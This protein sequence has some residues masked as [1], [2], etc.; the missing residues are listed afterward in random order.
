MGYNDWYGQ[1]MQ[2]ETAQSFVNSGKGVG[3]YEQ[4]YRQNGAESRTKVDGSTQS[5]EGT[6][7]KPVKTD[8]ASS[9]GEHTYVPWEDELLSAAQ[10]KGALQTKLAQEQMELDKLNQ[11]R[12]ALLETYTTDPT[13]DNAL[14]YELAD[15]QYGIANENYNK[16]FDRYDKTYEQEVLYN[17]AFRWNKENEGAESVL[18]HA[19]SEKDIQLAQRLMSQLQ[20]QIATRKKA[21][22][23][24]PSERN[25]LLLNTA[26][27]RYAEQLGKYGEIVDT[28]N[29][30]N[31]PEEIRAQNKYLQNMIET[32]DAK[33]EAHTKT[34]EGLIEGFLE[35]QQQADVFRATRDIYQTE[36]DATG[37][38]YY[39]SA[40]ERERARM[41]EDQAAQDAY[42][43]AIDTEQDIRYINDWITA[44]LDA[45]PDMVTGYGNRNIEEYLAEA[46]A[47]IKEKYGIDVKKLLP[48]H[49]DENVLNARNVLG[50]IVANLSE[51]LPQFT[52]V[53]AQ[54]GYN[55]EYM[56]GYDAYIEAKKQYEE[57]EK[58]HREN[59]D[60]SGWMAFGAWLGSTAVKPFSGIE[61]LQDVVGAIGHSDLEDLENYIP[62][63]TYDNDVTNYVNVS[64]DA[65]GNSYF[66][67]SGFGRFAYNVGTSAVDSAVTKAIAAIPVVGKGLALASTAGAAA[68]D[69]M[70]DIAA[71]GGTNDQMIVGG[72]AAGIVEVVAEDI[73]IEKLFGDENLKKTFT[74]TLVEQ[75]LTEFGEEAVTEALMI[76]IDSVN[77]SGKSEFDTAVNKYMKDGY[78]R[79]DAQSKAFAD[80]ILRVFEAGTAG[81]FGGVLSAGTVGA[82]ARR[83]AMS[84]IG[85]DYIAHGGDVN[86]LIAAG[87]NA[88]PNSNA[89]KIAQR[90][91]QRIADG[92]NVGERQIGAGLIALD[93]Q[94][95]NVDNNAPVVDDVDATPET[96]SEIP[97]AGNEKTAS[98]ET[99]QG[100]I[101]PFSETEANN[102]SSHKGIVSG[103]GIT[104]RQFID[105]I[106]NIGNTVRYYFGKVSS[107]LGARISSATGHDVS[108][109]NIAIRSDE[110]LHTFSHHGDAKKEALRGHLPVTADVLER[111]PEVFNAPDDVVPLSE[112]D[113]AGR[114]AFEIRKY[115]DGQMVV[116]VGIS[117][118][119]HSIEIDTVYVIDKKRHPTTV[120]AAQDAPLDHTSETSS[121]E[122]TEGAKSRLLDAEASQL[123]PI[124]SNAHSAP[125]ASEYTDTTNHTVAQNNSTVNEGNVSEDGIR[126]AGNAAEID[127]AEQ[128]RRDYAVGRIT[129]E[130]FDQ[131][132]DALMEEESASEMGMV[133]GIQWAGNEQITETTA[134]DQDNN[135]ETEE[136]TYEE[137][138]G[139]STARDGARIGEY[140][141]GET[142]QDRGRRAEEEAQ[143]RSAER[144]QIQ[145][146]VK[147]L[148]VPLTS[149]HECGLSI[150]SKIRS[151][152]IIPQEAWTDSIQRAADIAAE[153]GLEFVPLTGILCVEI[154]GKT[155]RAEAVIENG[156]IYVQAD[157]IQ[158]DVVEVTNHEV[159]HAKI[160]GDP[161][162]QIRLVNH[163]KQTYN[164]E[165]ISNLIDRYMDIYNEFVD[166]M[167]PE[168]MEAYVWKEM[169]ADAY[170]DLERLSGTKGPTQWGEYV[171]G[172]MAQAETKNTAQEDGVTRMSIE[173]LPDGKKYVRAD[174]QVLYGNDPDAWSEQLEDY[175]NGK[176]RRGQDVQLLTD[177]GDVLTLTAN[178]AGKVSSRY[179]N[180]GTTMSD[181]AFERKANAGAH[182]DELAQ[183]SERGK[184]IVPD[185]DGK[186]GDAARDGWNYRTAFFEDFDGRRYRC[187]ISVEIGKD[188][189]A[190]YNIGKMQER[191]LPQFS[192]PSVR[193]GAQGGETSSDIS[194]S[195]DGENSNRNFSF[196]GEGAMTA[197]EAA[198]Q[199][200]KDMLADGEDMETIRQETGWYQGR[201]GKWRFEIDDSGMTYH[202][203]GDAQFRKDHPEYARY[204]DLQMRFIEGTITAEEETELR[205]LHEIW[206]REYARLSERVDEGSATLGSILDHEELYAAYPQLR[207]MVVRFDD[208][209][210]TKGVINHRRGVITLDNS[211]RNAPEGTLLHEIQHAIQE[212]EGFAKGSSPE[213]WD[214]QGYEDA[215]DRYRNTAGEIEARDVANRRSLTAEERRQRMPELG[216]EQTVFAENSY[217][218]MSESEQIGIREQL[219]ENQDKLNSMDVVG[220]VNTQEYA[221]LDTGK[222][223]EK[224]MTEMK[225]TG[226]K[227][228]R[229]G[230]GEIRFEEREINNSL[231]YK[232]KS[233]SAEDARRTGFLVL[234]NVLKRGIEIGGHDDH[235]GRN[236][237]TVTIAAPIEI[238]GERGNMAVVVKRTKGN[239]YKV[240][241]ILTPKGETFM[242]PEMANAEMNT[243]GAF[244]NGS[245]SLGGSAPA[246]NSASGSIISKDV[247]GVNTR[248]SAAASTEE[249]TDS[250]TLPAK[251]QSYLRQTQWNLTNRIGDLMDV[252]FMTRRGGL[253]DAVNRLANE[254]LQRGD[255]SQQTVDELFDVASGGRYDTD[256]DA[257][258]RF[259]N[260]VY[261][262]LEELRQI[263]RYVEDRA[264]ETATAEP[265]TQEDVKQLYTE[266]KTARRTAEKAV[267]KNL[268]TAEDE[269]QIGRLL[270]GEITVDGLDAGQYN[271]KG[272]KAVYEARAEHERIA[273][274]IRQWN[275]SRK[276][277]L[278]EDAD[279]FLQTANDWKDKSA[280]LLYSRETMERNIRDIVKD[281]E[282]AEQIIAEYFE[283]V[284]RG[285]AEANK[286][287]N[288]YRSEVKELNLSRK[289]EK[290]NV[291]S[292]AHAVQLLGEA[293]DNIQMLEQSKGRMKS[294][295]GKTL[296]E[297]RGVVQALWENN[298]H[299]NEAKIRSAVEAF[300][301][302]YDE[303]FVQMNEVRIR[304]GYEPINYRNGYFPHFQPGD[305]GIMAL[306]GKAL[307]IDTQV[308]ALPTTING[309]THTFRPGITWFGNAQE[310]LGFNTAYD[311]V[312]GFDRYIEGVADVIFHTDN[313]QRLR[314]LASQIRYRTGDEGIR[315]QVDAVRADT[316]L[317]EQDK[318]N[319]IEKIYE[320]GKYSL[321]NFV[322]EL[323]E[324]TNLLANK[325]SR[326]D[327]DIESD[328]GRKIYT[329]VKNLESRVA[330]NMVAVNPASWLTNFIPLTQGNAALEHGMLLR[331]MWNTLRAY[332]KTDDG[333]VDMSSFL[334]NRRG[335]DPIVKSWQDRASGKLS[336]P[337]EYIDQ[338][339]ADSLVRARY[340]QNL[341]HG[342]SEDASMREAD[343]WVAGVMADRSKGSM[344]TLFGRKNPMTKLFTQFQLEVNNQ[345]SYVMK[346]VPRDM[347]SKGAMALVAALIKFCLG[348][349][350]FDELYEY[351]IGR[352]PALDPLGIINDT[353]G[354]FTGY[355]LP[356]LVEMG[357]GAIKG[358]RPDF[359]TEKKGAYGAVSG[360]L[361][362]VAEEM[363]FVGGLLGGGRIPI[364]SALPDG[365]K[366][367]NAAL[368]SDWDSEKRWK[369]AV[370]ELGSSAAYLIPPFGGG[371]IKKIVETVQAVHNHGSYNASGNLQYPVFSDSPL[372]W[373]GSVTK[374]VLFGKS[375]L[376]PAVEW[377]ES[378]FDGLSEKYTAVYQIMLELGED[379]RTAWAVT[380][381]LAD[382]E[383]TGEESVAVVRRDILREADISA[384]AKLAIYYDICANDKEKTLIE[385]M[386][387]EDPQ[388]VYELLD[389]MRGAEKTEDNSEAEV[390]R[391]MLIE[392]DLPAEAKLEVYT[393]NYASDKERAMI[394]SLTEDDPE[395]IYEVVDGIKEAGNNTDKMIVLFT[396]DLRDN[397]KQAV[398]EYISESD[399]E[400][401]GA[402]SNYVDFDVYGRFLQSFVREYGYGA[403]SQDEVEYILDHTPGLS[404]QE[405]AAIWQI[406]NKGW[407]PKNNP[408][409]VEVGQRIYDQMN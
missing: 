325:K 208:L 251:A 245:Q 346:D 114:T 72:L 113:Y 360:L 289:V 157:S 134:E 216:N 326:H 124:P 110:V 166:G 32:Y 363:P 201:D 23:E 187:T 323:E 74:R 375:S 242:L 365:E 403:K 90:L 247:D 219:R 131:A 171:R 21:Y 262:A 218:F 107:S 18:R 30:Y 188:G 100:G 104:F 276:A 303:L 138:R 63:N 372:D 91:Q 203:G 197:D 70:H 272:I 225:K 57:W 191:S 92:K 373:A 351:L 293:E 330:A 132:M 135:T 389:G 167:T 287:K 179:N 189:N 162:L 322:V 176:V 294:R 316:T 151:N 47:R 246:I 387:D 36:Y 250:D 214:N 117:N 111:L 186:H 130:E 190:V 344:P 271:V 314:A 235:K 49:S 115:L 175:I 292:E 340:Y 371:Q 335:S 152:R 123:R 172:E 331:G 399:G 178:T 243:V 10:R 269:V 161:D 222:A 93:A 211:L 359:K 196:A 37:S 279:T 170:A 315:K 168:D 78:N 300:R 44:R 99:E 195:E 255:V 236:Y 144:S 342:M 126:W 153:N 392:S 183:I 332:G 297:W 119:K 33:I 145:S 19:Q 66:G 333:I 260:A 184:S 149:L 55:Y 361:G 305:G 205:E 334:T 231:N 229:Q 367:L 67:D 75:G 395:I 118:G 163:I 318:Q 154:K 288:D 282:L 390:E 224:L 52:S 69:T 51:R 358:K 9:K 79:K 29:Y 376:D 15:A 7:A 283:P 177:D 301:K 83:N 267:A 128:L 254:Y 77:M 193:D 329:I 31:S 284:H 338:F 296:E 319:R 278:R 24:D 233:Q 339:V 302:I 306:F 354:D 35:E 105:N 249:S 385:S 102:L 248:F 366:L 202:R 341:K 25:A 230:F 261:E 239:R 273:K 324:Y 275:Q 76:A 13:E 101:I 142:A 61:Y 408:Y 80:M 223:R 150:G 320:S 394:E 264:V 266:L 94:Q 133:D 215:Q 227:V 139:Q 73:G 22:E 312:E 336:A 108:G 313:I 379:D 174:R 2:G 308:S 3:R 381:Q 147:A 304:N 95:M 234:Q 121:G 402:A 40:R 27:A 56:R 116:V 277:Q 64:R 377:V 62:I 140:S 97:W 378:G 348:A 160:E 180:D 112:K 405:R 39:F 17:N 68:S 14:A 169:L 209:D 317:A 364:S 58:T 401:F 181:E 383:A 327:R 350:L 362:N 311:A 352:R 54:R 38:R 88:D 391:Q 82:F 194:I 396:S 298:P 65:V 26:T 81:F 125:G 370:K 5:K 228:N 281:P 164:E 50:S 345:L 28:Y 388:E 60:G 41:S 382:A 307:G 406:C 295:D 241:R 286:L 285:T 353:V 84:G 1:K 96:S 409:S 256:A 173:T 386:S 207:D 240:H 328:V 199:I 136:M 220:R 393:E 280:G 148:G 137:N 89:Y 71:R 374:G 43:G 268:L 343:A 384:E 310:R 221:G 98:G 53:L 347:R 337:M 380:K 192:G 356:N 212:A 198:L 141:D 265:L 210:G 106:K 309:L 20:Q 165:E 34:E 127:P 129:E 146:D 6:G 270:R 226:Y 213:Y 143:R 407:K 400:K 217:F 321:S 103:H 8:G 259:E 4:W 85:Q 87:L 349:F 237:D 258:E 369:T 404:D 206:G 252:S 185:Y 232:E 263:R 120:N 109:F 204:Q 290:G 291:V 253:R 155:L 86:D 257:R 45:S 357:V 274:Q 11:E 16:L 156:V 122:V 200:A 244:T 48:S 398:L 238:N 397:D 159:F 46:E 158:R 12:L 355:E 299:L 59:I 368:N 182:I 42:Q